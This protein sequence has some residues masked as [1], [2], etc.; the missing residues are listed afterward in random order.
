MPRRKRTR[1]ESDVDDNDLTYSLLG[2][3]SWLTINTKT[4][5]ISGLPGKT[6]VE[7]ISVERQSSNQSG[8]TISEILSIAIETWADFDQEAGV[9][10]LNPS[11][12]EGGQHFLRVI[13]TDSGTREDEGAE[14]VDRLTASALVPLLVRHRNSAPELQITS[15]AELLDDSVLEGV[16]SAT[17]QQGS[18]QQLT[19]LTLE[20]EEDAEI[21]IELPSSLYGDIDLSID[22]AE[23]LTYSFLTEQDLP[24]TLDP[25]SLSISGNTDGL[26]LQT[27]GGRS[28]WA[29]KLVVADAAGETASFD[30]ELILQ[31]SAAEPTLTTILEPEEAYWDEGTPVP[32]AELL[33]LSLEPRSGEVVE[34]L[35]ERT[36]SDTQTLQ[37]RDEHQQAIPPKNDGSWLLRGSAEE[38][39]N[40]ITELSLVVENDAHAIGTFALRA[41]ATSELGST[42]LRSE[43]VTAAIGFTLEPD[44]TPPRWTKQSSEGPTD[45]LALRTFADFLSA[46]LVDPREQLL[47]AI[48]LPD[49]EQELMITDRT[50][51]EIGEREGQEVILTAE[52]WAV[53]MLRTEEAN[54]Q[55]V[56]MTVRALSE[57]VSIG[58]VAEADST[59]NVNWQPTPLLQ[60]EP[61]G[62][63]ITPD[64]VQRSGEPTSMSLALI[65][66]E[67]AQSGQIQIDVPLGTEIEIEGLEGV[68][69]HSKE[70]D[71][72]VEADGETVLKKKQR[73]LFTVKA[74]GDQPIPSDLDLKVTSPETFDG[75]FEGNFELLSSV[76]NDLPSEGLSPEAFAAD[77]N[78]GFVSRHASEWGT[79]FWDVAQVAKTPE[80]A[81]DP[82]LRFDPDTGRDSNWSA[83]RGKQLR[84]RLSQSSRSAHHLGSEYS[85]GLH[86]GLSE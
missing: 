65:W 26:G 80:F 48:D 51:E 75:E 50:G 40:Q 72:E 59:V 77:Q 13:A 63:A 35:L 19:G 76:R 71:V 10:T 64:G 6:Q 44:A 14:A 83:T 27:V 74:V 18:D 69:T 5:E 57:E 73:F 79:F 9:L 20:L 12:E 56:N 7:E 42:G 34:L 25:N 38:V 60:E 62:L 78:N 37:L 85:I 39:T 24:F 4:G 28:S 84:L 11:V 61:L 41:T 3:P 1:R 52:E 2:A 86:P 68:V 55:T 66:P 17:P 36:D 70:I 16:F 21:F 33:D 22:P 29:T 15:S 82:D 49:T 8:E 54:P 23:R 58:L 45:P 81:P 46:E 67:V 47:Y 43:T 32:L 31:R 53:A 30:L